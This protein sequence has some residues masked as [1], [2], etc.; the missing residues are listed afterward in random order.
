MFND[1]INS[2]QDSIQIWKWSILPNDVWT[3]RINWREKKIAIKCNHT[4]TV[5]WKQNYFRIFIVALYILMMIIPNIKL[6]TPHIHAHTRY[7]HNIAYNQHLADYLQLKIN[8]LLCEPLNI[9][10][11][12]SLWSIYK[13]RNDHKKKYSTNTH[14]QKWKTANG[15]SSLA[16][17]RENVS[18]YMAEFCNKNACFFVWLLIWIQDVNEW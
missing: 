5:E 17:K 4:W 6:W 14:T 1:K 18:N 9:I 16:I 12:M 2:E 13:Q 15:P 3:K 7:M 11:C 8:N 10:W